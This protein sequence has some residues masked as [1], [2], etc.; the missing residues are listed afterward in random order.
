M[1]SIFRILL[2]IAV[3]LGIFYVTNTYA[4]TPPLSGLVI[5]ASSVEF[6]PSPDHDA[7]LEGT[8]IP[9]VEKYFLAVYLYGDSGEDPEVMVADL[10]KPVPDA[11][12]KRIKWTNR[13]WFTK[14]GYRK[15][16]Y[17]EV[18]AVGVGGSGVSAESN[19]FVNVDAPAPVPSIPVVK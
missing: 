2:L 4:Q 12:T 1:K 7:I 5:N 11:T 18:R 3:I 9:I 16:F 10:G 6:D 8:E 15:V 13:D 14:L 17:A 19:P